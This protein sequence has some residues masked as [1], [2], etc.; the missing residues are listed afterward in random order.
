MDIVSK[1][2]FG[3]VLVTAPFR[4]EGDLIKKAN[5]TN[6]GLGAAVW[7]SD[8]GKAHRT[9]ASI[10][11]GTVWINCYNVLDPSLPFGGYKESGWGREMGHE[12]LHQYTQTKTNVVA[13]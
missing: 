7:T 1:E 5:D 8:I 13:L 11:A 3:P 2:I 4:D 9:A 12:V 6:Y 10:K